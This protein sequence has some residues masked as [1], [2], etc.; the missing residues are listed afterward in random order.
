MSD[1]NSIAGLEAILGKAPPAVNLKVIDHAD[2]TAR[3]WLEAS[4]LMFAGFGDANGIAITLGGGGAGF[5]V[6]DHKTLAIP[7]A[8]LDDPA[9]AVPGASFG[10]LF[11]VPGIGETLR[12]N[13]RVAAVA[14]GDVQVAVEECYVHCAKALIRSGFWSADPMAAAPAASR[15]FAAAASFMALATIDAA[16]HADLSPKGDPAGSMAHLDGD[17][18]WFADRPGNRR[19]DSFRNLIVQPRIAAALLIP[20]SADVAILRGTAM[21]TDDETARAT[22]A[23]QG[24]VPL[25][26][27]RVDDV[28]IERRSSAALARAALWPAAPAPADIKPAK[29]FAEHVRLNKDKGLGARIAGAF[30]SVPGLM[31]RGLDKDYKDNLY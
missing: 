18:L 14:D 15:A 31:Q 26:A 7:L 11:L 4:R 13:G 5:A 24:K 23:V 2:A 29:M 12:I 28:V 25:L 9:L 3:R 16:G 19:T 6:A 10:S 27:T 30:V 1:V 22:F 8:A 21:L 20:G 17:Q